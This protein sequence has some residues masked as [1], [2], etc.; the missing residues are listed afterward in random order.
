MMNKQLMK[1]I[2]HFISKI[3]NKSPISLIRVR[4]GESK[5]ADTISLYTIDGEYIPKGDIG[6]IEKTIEELPKTIYFDLESNAYGTENSYFRIYA[7]RA[8]GKQIGTLQRSTPLKDQEEKQITPIETPIHNLVDGFLQMAQTLQHTMTSTIGT[9]SDTLA[10]REE[11]TIRMLES[12][13][14]AKEE[15]VEIES[16]AREALM[17]ASITT[18]EDSNPMQAEAMAHLGKIAS[19]LGGFGPTPSPAGQPTKEQ[20]REWAKDPNFVMNAA[21]VFQEMQDQQAEEP[22]ETNV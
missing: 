20:M 2:T 10:H 13:V 9:L 21:Q 4:C 19:A 11:L 22:G 7:Y 14:E 8:D 18:T 1:D 15:R 17:N 3:E 6:V 16:I 5:D 12:M